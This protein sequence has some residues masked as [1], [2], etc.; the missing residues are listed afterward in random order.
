MPTSISMC[1]GKPTSMPELLV[2]V[3]VGPEGEG[4]VIVAEPLVCKG[5]ASLHYFFINRN[6][7]TR[8]LA[9]DRS[10]RQTK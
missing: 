1:R 8:C 6:G 4:L 9:C 10:G 7:Q 5:C 3:R 2:L